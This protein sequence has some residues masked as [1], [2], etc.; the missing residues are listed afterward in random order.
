M[1]PNSELIQ[2]LY[3]ISMSIGTDL[4]LRSTLRTSLS[5]ILKK[6]NCTAGGVYQ[7]NPPG[8]NHPANLHNVYSIPRHAVRNPIYQL[9]LHTIPAPQNLTELDDYSK[10]LPVSG[11]EKD[12]G[13]YHI[14]NLENFGFLILIKNRTPLDHILLKSLKSPIEKLASACKTCL[15]KEE[16]EN[17]K[18]HLEEQAAERTQVLELNNFLLKNEI[19]EREKI[20]N[21]LKEQEILLRNTLESTADGILVVETSGKVILKNQKFCT[22]WNIP[23]ELL[24]QNEEGIILKYTQ[25]K[26]EK[27]ENYISDIK[28]LYTSTEESLERLQ[29]RD[30]RVFERYSLPLLKDGEI[31]GRVWSF[32]DISELNNQANFLKEAKEAAEAANQAKSEFLANI[33]HEIRTPLAG[34]VGIAELMMFT[35][36][37]QEQLEYNEIISISAD[38]LMQLI[39]NTLD[40]SKLESDSY[41]LNISPFNI[42]EI[43]PE[44]ITLI[45]NRPNEKN[46]KLSYNLDPDIPAQILGDTSCIRQIVMNLLENALKFTMEGEVKLDVSIEENLKERIKER[47]PRLIFAI[48][49][50]GPGIEVQNQNAIFEKFYQVDSSFTREHSGMGLGLSIARELVNLLEGT[51]TLE[52]EPGQGSTFYVK[53]PLLL[54][55]PAKDLKNEKKTVHR[56]L[57]QEKNQAKQ[58]FVRNMFLKL[59]ATVDFASDISELIWKIPQEQWDYIFFELSESGAGSHPDI[60]Q[61]QN[62]NQNVKLVGLTPRDLSEEKQKRI[63]ESGIMYS[64]PQPLQQDKLKSIFRK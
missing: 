50:T 2:I 47:G 35:E 13:F 16:L 20:Q 1:R 28:E 30:G 19:A 24:K 64:I 54:P 42:H 4:D 52:S 36:M 51:I 10:S 40:F 31:A 61:I 34:I 8:E 14:L 12:R 63:R 62:Q 15:Q 60:L 48:S 43:V 57:F 53:L 59:G 32:R 21:R 45:S 29:L 22:M 5:T 46:I 7:L 25:K 3:E 17:H 56:I 39:N 9:A 58:I 44:I 49:D 55:V 27:S 38:N 33:S 26:I 18:I 23:R 6:L 11:G 37:S 41:E